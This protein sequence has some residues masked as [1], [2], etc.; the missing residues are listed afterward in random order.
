MVRILAPAAALVLGGAILVHAG[1]RRTVWMP[2]D[3]GGTRP[4]LGLFAG[5][6]AAI[7]CRDALARAQAQPEPEDSAPSP[8]AGTPPGLRGHVTSGPEDVRAGCRG[9]VGLK[10]ATSVELVPPPDACGAGL[11]K[12]RVLDGTYRGRIGCVRADGLRVP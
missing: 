12:V 4:E 7:A 3:A 8:G 5:R 1:A 6:D 10:H 2:P 9:V 11:S